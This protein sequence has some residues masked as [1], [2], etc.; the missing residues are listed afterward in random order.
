MVPE[1]E[2]A[3]ICPPVM[4]LLPGNQVEISNDGM[5]TNDSSS[6][7]DEKSSS[8]PVTTG[9]GNSVDLYKI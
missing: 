6:L 2:F 1:L 3:M 7:S 9:T 8:Q 4:Q 5:S